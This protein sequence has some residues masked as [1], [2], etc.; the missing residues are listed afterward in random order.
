MKQKKAA[1]KVEPDK[2]ASD[3][4]KVSEEK[5][6]DVA[7]PG[8]SMPSASGRPIIV[9]HKPGV[10]DPM[11]APQKADE[12]EKADENPDTPSVGEGAD[13]VMAAPKKGRIEPLH[14]EITSDE[15]NPNVSED[16]DTTND[17][18]SVGPP[19]PEANEEDT[20]QQDKNDEQN[21]EISDI[22]SEVTTK[23]EAQNEA[24]KKETEASK[25]KTEVEALV[26]N[27]QFFVPI[28]AVQ[29]RRSMKLV[30][31]LIVLALAVLVSLVVLDAGW[32]DIG[33]ASPTDFIKE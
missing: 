11:V 8:K 26:T 23:K 30:T 12:T 4:G 24:A 32:V 13:M 18:E 22:A 20:P 6:F 9:T 10:T 2:K 21:D 29:K 19:E 7:R 1:K 33:I 17:E 27:R 3:P 16:E 25:K 5:V 15:P 28:N 31:L 14:T